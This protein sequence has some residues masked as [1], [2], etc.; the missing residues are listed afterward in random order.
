MLI[1][2]FHMKMQGKIAYGGFS[3]VE[4]MCTLPYLCKNI[5]NMQ[6]GCIPVFLLVNQCSPE[7]SWVL[8]ST[9][10]S[11]CSMS[12]INFRNFKIT[13]MEHFNLF[14]K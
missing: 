12:S 6:A 5:A 13:F 7:I 14:N 2:I 10:S 1:I 11:T 8:I 4:K 3:Y 9:I